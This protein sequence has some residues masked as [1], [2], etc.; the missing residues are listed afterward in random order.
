MIGDLETITKWIHSLRQSDH[1]AADKLWNSFGK[2][3]ESVAKKELSRFPAVTAFDEEDVALSAFA[4]FCQ[5]LQAGKFD[6]LEDRQ[7]LWW[8]LLVITKRKAGDRMKYERAGKRAMPTSSG[9]DGEAYADAPCEGLTPYQWA[10]MREQCEHLLRILDD[11]ELRCL[12]IWK[13]EGRTNEE[14]AS[15]LGRTRQTVQRKLALIRSVWQQRLEEL[16][17]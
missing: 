7:Q 9:E 11:D 10:A 17:A 8:L 6:Q 1:R 15:Q 14:I 2:R 12:A 3:I 4:T 13:L 5:Q 16:G